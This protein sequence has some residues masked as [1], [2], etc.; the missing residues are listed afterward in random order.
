MDT[1]IYGSQ[2]KNVCLT[3][4][5]LAKRWQFSIKAKFRGNHNGLELTIGDKTALS[6]N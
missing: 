3:L 1:Q 6:E 5:S 2:K 4:A